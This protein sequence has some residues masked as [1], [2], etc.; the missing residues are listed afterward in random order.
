M[1]DETERSLVA[2]LA[3]YHR[4]AWPSPRHRRFAALGKDDRKCVRRL[5][6]LLRLADALDYSRQGLVEDI[7]ARIGKKRVELCLQAKAPCRRKC[8]GPRSRETFLKPSSAGSC[9]VHACRNEVPGPCR[10]SRRVSGNGEAPGTA[11]QPGKVLG[12]F[13]LGSNSVRLMLVRVGPVNASCTVL[14]QVKHMVRLGEGV[15]LHGRLHE[16]AMQ[17]TVHVLQGMA[18]M[19]SAYGVTD[20]VACATAA[21]RDADNAP[22]F[23]KRVREHT[24]LTFTVISGREEARL[25]YLGVASGL[26]YSEENRLFIDIGGGSTELIVGNSHNFSNLDS[27]KVGCVRLSNQFFGADDGPASAARYRQVQD[28]IRNQLLHAVKRIEGYDLAEAVGSSGTI[29]NLAAMAAAADQTGLG[30]KAA[31]SALSDL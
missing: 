17:R 29:Q 21:V 5:A 23:L 9:A 14:N 31:R 30:K 10:R 1:P 19:C 3:R 13:D 4:R 2:L 8:A 18:G 24:G 6:A 11:V 28:A 16:E 22:V 7:S 26:E 25:I 20:I 15:F 27:V 12:I